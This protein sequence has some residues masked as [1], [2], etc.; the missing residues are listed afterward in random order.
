VTDTNMPTS[1]G[2]TVSASATTG[3]MTGKVSKAM[4][5]MAWITRVS[6]RGSQA[7]TRA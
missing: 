2:E 6:S 7:F 5:T 3:A 4:E 1:A